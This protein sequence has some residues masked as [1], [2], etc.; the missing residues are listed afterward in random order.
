METC[1]QGN[2]P[3]PQRLTQFLTVPPLYSEGQHTRLGAGS[4]RGQIDLYPRQVGQPL[5]QAADQILL[6]SGQPS[7]L[8]P[9]EKAQS[10]Q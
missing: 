3:P 9:L 6:P 10:L 8:P 1:P 2:S 5:P 7:L 4:A